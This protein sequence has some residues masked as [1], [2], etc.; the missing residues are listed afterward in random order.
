M[1]RLADYFVVDGGR[2]DAVLLEGGGDVG[3][4]VGGD[5]FFAVFH[6]V[7]ETTAEMADEVLLY[8]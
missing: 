3:L 1:G 4:L 6:V 2:V 8:G 5:G 7:V